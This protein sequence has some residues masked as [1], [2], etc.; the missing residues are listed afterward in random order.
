M[1]PRGQRHEETCCPSPICKG[2][3]FRDRQFYAYAVS[4]DGVILEFL[5]GTL[6]L[7]LF[8]KS[9]AYFLGRP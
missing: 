9:H 8:L 1:E 3:K 2:P 5:G 4:T 7:L 6:S